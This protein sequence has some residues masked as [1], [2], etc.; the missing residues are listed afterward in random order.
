MNEELELSVIQQV[1]C[2]LHGDDVAWLVGAAADAPLTY[3]QLF[4][5]TD[6]S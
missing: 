6:F 5:K 4:A 2:Q 1:P 3:R